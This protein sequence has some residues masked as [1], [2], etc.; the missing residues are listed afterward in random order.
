MKTFNAGL[1]HLAR[2]YWGVHMTWGVIPSVVYLLGLSMSSMAARS[3]C[4]ALLFICE[5]RHTFTRLASCFME[6]SWT[7]TK[8]IHMLEWPSN[9]RTDR[10]P[11][12]PPHPVVLDEL[13]HLVFSQVIGLDV[14]LN[15]LLVGNGPQ[16]RQLLQLHQELLK[17]QL[18]QGPALVTALLH[19]RIS[20]REHTSRR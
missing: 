17:V 9:N 8:V 15:K 13:L 7:E 5:P 18:H 4:R 6:Y 20:T 19:I 16:V 2:V 12:S 11:P 3:F 10:P 14:G 1:H